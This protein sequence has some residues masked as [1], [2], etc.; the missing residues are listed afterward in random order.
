MA[1]DA[2][3][4]TF[5]AQDR[6]AGAGTVPAAEQVCLPV[7]AR[8]RGVVKRTRERSQERT[9]PVARAPTIWT[10][11][12][13]IACRTLFRR[14]GSNSKSWSRRAAGHRHSVSAPTGRLNGS[15]SRCRSWFRSVHLRSLST[16][17]RPSSS[18]TRME[19]LTLRAS[20]MGKAILTSGII[21]H[22]VLHRLQAVACRLW[23]IRN[24]RG[25]IQHSIMT[26]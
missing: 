20:T 24:H 10:I 17:A 8:C 21:L 11:D 13:G 22:G 25:G 12:A 16:R 2:G 26:R 23:G 6:G 5:D 18:V 1:H 3:A 15:V 9:S 4:G 19:L 14:T 7:D